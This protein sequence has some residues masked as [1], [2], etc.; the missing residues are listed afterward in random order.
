MYE[1]KFFIDKVEYSQKFDVDY[2]GMVQKFRK[3]VKLFKQK[4]IF[5]DEDIIHIY[6]DSQLFNVKNLH[7]KKLKTTDYYWSDKITR[8]QFNDDFI[9]A[10]LI[11]WGRTFYLNYHLLPKNISINLLNKL[12]KDLRELNY[13]FNIDQDSEELNDLIE[14]FCDGAS[15][16]KILHLGQNGYDAI[17]LNIIEKTNKP[18]TVYR[19]YNWEKSDLNFS[20]WV[21][22]CTVKGQYDYLHETSEKEF[23]LPI[24]FPIINTIFKGQQ[25]CDTNELIIRFEDLM[26]LK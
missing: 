19:T 5:V 21:S 9:K 22:V 4:E 24:G 12:L 15:M 11:L 16:N 18:L 3:M 2:N 10:A 26:S 25:L 14:W 7:G 8:I 23:H 17:L 1:F 20:G 6:K 13:L